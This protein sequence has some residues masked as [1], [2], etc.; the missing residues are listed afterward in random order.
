MKTEFSRTKSR[1]IKKRNQRYNFINQIKLINNIN[2]N[3]L[4]Y[5]LKKQKIKLNRKILSNFFLSEIGT[6]LSLKS[7]LKSFYRI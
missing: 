2:Y 6:T 4:I 5:V 3:L 1:K 7:L